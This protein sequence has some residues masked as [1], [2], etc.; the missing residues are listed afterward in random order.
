MF[1][2]QITYRLLRYM[3][4]LI[5]FILF[6][7]YYICGDLLH[8]QS[9]K[10]SPSELLVG[11]DIVSFFNLLPGICIIVLTWIIRKSLS[12]K[13]YFTLLTLGI[14]PAIALVIIGVVSNLII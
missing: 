9:K 11:V 1:K 7:G 3:I 14:S 13:E 6:F 4:Y 10:T 8:E 2:K 5:S 12:R